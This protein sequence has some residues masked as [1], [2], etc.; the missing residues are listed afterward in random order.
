MLLS[1]LVYFENSSFKM[2]RTMAGSLA[3]RVYGAGLQEK[4]RFFEM[5]RPSQ[6]SRRQSCKRYKFRCKSRIQPA[7]AS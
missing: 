2:W 1:G 4:P 6:I 3:S 5:G 7:G